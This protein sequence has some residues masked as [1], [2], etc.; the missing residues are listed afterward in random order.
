MVRTPARSLLH[1]ANLFDR[2]VQAVSFL[3]A[4]ARRERV[5]YTNVL[6]IP[7]TV[8]LFFVTG[9]YTELD[10]CVS[11]ALL[12]IDLGH[13]ACVRIRRAGSVLR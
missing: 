8:V 11:R 12:N 2:S 1:P 3:P 9:E 13:Y 6:G 4:C 5:L 10:K 7:P